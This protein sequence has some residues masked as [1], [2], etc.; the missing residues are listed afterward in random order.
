MVLVF[1]GFKSFGQTSILET[2]YDSLKLLGLINNFESYSILPNVGL[3]NKSAGYSPPD[4]SFQ[5]AISPSDDGSSDLI[6]LPFDFCFYGESE[7][8]VYINNNGNIS[9]GG[10]F[11][12]STPFDFPFPGFKVIA[13]FWSDVDTRARGGVFYKLLPNALIVNW[14]DVGHFDQESS[15]GNS[16]QLII[17]D[18]TSELLPF[19]N[20]VGFFYSKL[21]WTAGSA[22]GGNA[23]FGGAPAICGINAGDGVKYSLAG[24]YDK[25]DT[26][27]FHAVDSLNGVANLINQHN[28]FNPCDSVNQKPGLMG[29]KLRDTIGVCVGDTFAE[30]FRFLPPEMDQSAYVIVTSSTFPGFSLESTSSGQMATA[31]VKVVGS[32]ANMGFHRLSFKVVDSGSPNQLMDFDIIVQV[33]SLPEPLNIMGDSVICSYD[34]VRLSV[35]NIYDTYL[36]NTASVDT[37]IIAIPGNYSVTVSYNNCES[38]E[39]YK[40]IGYL[41]PANIDAPKFICK[42]NSIKLNGPAGLDQYAWSTGDTTSSINI[43]TGGM[44]MLTVTNQGC[45]NTDSVFVNDSLSV[46]IFTSNINSC[47]GDSVVLSVGSDYDQVLWSTLETTSSIKVLAGTYSVYVT[48]NS[49]SS[50]SCYAADTII[51]SNANIIPLTISG[52]SFICGSGSTLKKVDALYSSYSWDDGGDKQTN[53]YNTIGPHSVTVTDGTCLDSLSFNVSGRPDPVVAIQGNLFYCDDVD[54]ARLVAVGGNWDSINWSTGDVTDTIYTGFGWKKVTVWKDGCSSFAWHPVN[55]LIDGVDVDG[56]TEICPG[57]ATRLQ[58]EFG[59]DFYQWNTGA[60]GFSTLANAPGDYWCIVSL[61]TCSAS[62]DIVT[63]TMNTP[64][65]VEIFGDTVMCDS[66]GGVLFADPNYTQFNWSTGEITPSI[67]YT[68]AGIYSVTVQDRGYCVTSDTADVVQRAPVQVEI[69]GDQHYCFN[70]STFLSAG[71]F[72]SYLWSNGATISPL[73]ARA[74][75]YAVTVTDIYGCKGVDKDYKV[76]QSSP[77]ANIY[78]QDKVCLNDSVLVFTDAKANILWSTGDTTD[79]IEVTPQTISLKVIDSYKCESDSVLVMNYLA[80]PKARINVSPDNY[81]EAYLPVHFMDD[82]DLDGAVISEW[83]WNIGDVFKASSMDTSVTFLEGMEIVVI[84]ALTSDSGCTDTV[85]INYRI[86]DDIVK[87]NV[88]TPNGDGV[89]DYL[90]FPNLQKFPNNHLKI[91]NR[92]GVLIADLPQYRN[93]WDGNLVPDGTYFYTLYLE[94]GEPPLKGSFTILR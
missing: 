83:Y 49:Q 81:S 43:N 70:D 86:T 27:F 47:N 25:S 29:Y 71:N 45:F 64:D 14:E 21:E 94:E 16:Y 31:T 9:F 12:S 41:P 73:K 39:S 62:T 5:V 67:N 76:T 8:E 54:S 80:S 78:V 59:F 22:S 46:N 79:T 92:W 56:I 52:D 89:N 74:G 68:S 6:N 32:V 66:S 34:S 20:T 53:I 44:Y 60:I 3:N 2:E 77:Y 30:T 87:V 69:I 18:G 1:F 35:K 40:L 90:V 88:I 82:S 63:I 51:I 19:G 13:P 28:F 36:W 11:T 93:F 65:T 42:P 38:S 72:D 84:H 15:R 24:K 85:Q 33:D 48:L 4:G 7:T 10:V 50:L 58:V 61:D 37:S 57:Q 23:G 55:E 75:V 91:F 17:S 26:T